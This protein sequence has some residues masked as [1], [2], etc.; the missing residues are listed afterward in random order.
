MNNINQ[1]IFLQDVKNHKITILHDEGVYRHIKLREPET[2]VMS[3]HLI[4]GPGFLLY[5]GDMGCFVFE[6]LHDMFDFLFDFFREKTINPSYW[7]EKLEA[8]IGQEFSKEWFEETIND[9]MDQF[10]IDHEIGEEIA[11]TLRDEMADMISL[12]ETSQDAYE[13]VTNWSGEDFNANDMFGQDAWELK[14]DDYT[15]H[16]LWACYA[17]VW[18]I[19]K[20]DEAKKL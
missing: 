9:I 1:E 18:G 20:Y 17:I 3:F 19:A 10:I 16:Y 5:H 6:R 11:D 13:Q 2:S 7:H 4:T 8:G 14:F 12:V 15:F